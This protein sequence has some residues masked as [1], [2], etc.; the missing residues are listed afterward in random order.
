LKVLIISPIP[1]DKLGGPCTFIEN[2][3]KAKNSIASDVFYFSN[4]SN[5]FLNYQ[6]LI[7]L[8]TDL[9]LLNKAIKKSEIILIQDNQL[10]GFLSTLLSK[11]SK[12]KSIVRFTS[13]P[14][15]DRFQ[16]TQLDIF[17]INY[18]R[19]VL[20]KSQFKI[21]DA[22]VFPSKT[23]AALMQKKFNLVDTK[24]Y[25]IPNGI[26]I[27]INKI[28]NNRKDNSIVMPM[29]LEKIKRI[30]LVLESIESLESGLT[31]AIIGEGDDL[32]R[33]KGIVKEYRLCNVRFIGKLSNKNLYDELS[34]Y[35]YYL[36]I[37]NGE[38]FC[39]GMLEAIAAGCT[40]ILLDHYAFRDVLEDYIHVEY[41]PDVSIHEIRKGI[42]RALNSKV[43]LE[44]T[45]DERVKLLNKFN[46]EKIVQKYT[47]IFNL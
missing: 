32:E 30:D 33:L 45:L 31:L 1:K 26:A 37:S 19:S 40:P 29:R 15:I 47:E 35:E 42:S 38:T 18:F 9:T 5:G 28:T 43:N 25:V 44:S 17:S 12:K 3:L 8:F 13:D 10:L 36:N 21:S 27:N 22:T 41:I 20:L 46:V 11:I 4:Y 7:K 6:N 2:W 24:I 39:Y 23:F 16:N 14:T 34:N